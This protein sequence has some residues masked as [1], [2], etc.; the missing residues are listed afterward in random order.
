MAWIAGPVLGGVLGLII[1]VGV[2][3]SVLRR[4]RR[5]TARLMDT[6]D[7]KGTVTDS[8]RHELQGYGVSEMPA[9]PRRH[10]LMS[11]FNRHELQGDG[12]YRAE[13]EGQPVQ[14]YWWNPKTSQWER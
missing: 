7:E 3:W 5:K 4:R 10:E 11:S 2:V 8:P 14:P 6:T 12:K 1:I 13:L 9:D